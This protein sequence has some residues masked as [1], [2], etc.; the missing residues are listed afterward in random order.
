MYIE[1]WLVYYI[2]FTNEILIYKLCQYVYYNIR[3]GIAKT[4]EHIVP[5]VPLYR[6]SIKGDTREY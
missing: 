2:Y 4:Y 5:I 3:I 1:I 6:T